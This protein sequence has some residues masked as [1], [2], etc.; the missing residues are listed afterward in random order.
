[1]TIRKLL[2]KDLLLEVI[3]AINIE[4]VIY[5]VTKPR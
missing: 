3:V 4:L 1:M 5:A 2:G